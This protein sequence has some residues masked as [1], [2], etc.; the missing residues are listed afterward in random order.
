[1]NQASRWLSLVRRAMSGI[2]AGEINDLAESPISLMP[3][4]EKIEF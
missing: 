2:G 3:N 4:G 1:M